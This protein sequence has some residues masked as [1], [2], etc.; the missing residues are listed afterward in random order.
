MA[1]VALHART[2]EQLYSGAADW[3]AIGELKAAV[4]TIP[5]LGNGDIWEAADALAM[6]TADRVRRR[7]RRPR[8][9]RAAVAVR[10]PGGGLRRASSPRRRP[11]SARSSIVMA[12]HARLLVATGLG[13]GGRA[14]GLPQAHRLVPHRLPRAVL[15]SGGGW[16][17]SSSLG[18]ARRPPGRRSTPTSSWCRG[19]CAPIGA[20]PT[21]P[22]R[23]T[24]RTAG[25]TTPTTLAP[26]PAR[27]TPSCL[28]ED[29]RRPACRPGPGLGIA[30]APPAARS[31]GVRFAAIGARHRRD[32]AP[33]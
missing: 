19:V 2:A 9:P 20:T 23:S 22:D 13:E 6:V 7:R 32:A 14:A 21:V 17:R 25:W 11:A 5:V 30:P 4:T 26:L 18:R 1:A 16:P 3:A 28:G 15:R 10:R 27:P 8:L 24:S 12:D 29:D 31:I 33:G